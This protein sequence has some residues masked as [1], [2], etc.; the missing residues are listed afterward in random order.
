MY[1][2]EE[3]YLNYG[4]K[5]LEDAISRWRP[6][7]F[8]TFKSA[9]EESFLQYNTL[10]YLG[11]SLAQWSAPNQTPI[12][13]D[14]WNSEHSSFRE[15][16]PYQEEMTEGEA[17]VL[18]TQWD[19]KTR[20]TNLRRN[21]D[22]W[23]LPN[24]A[25]TMLG[26]IPD[27]VNLAGFGGFVGRMG[28]VSK[29]AK[30]LPAIKYTAPV[31]QGA[32]DTALAESLF[33]FTRATYEHTQGGDLDQFSIFGE[34]AL[35]TAFGGMFGTLPM[36]WQIAKKVPPAMHFTY[37]DEAMHRIGRQ[38]KS[39]DTFGNAGVHADEIDVDAETAINRN[40]QRE[41][42]TEA[43]GQLSDLD[44]TGNEIFE[45]ER[46]DWDATPTEE[47]KGI[48]AEAADDI[49]TT[50]TNPAETKRN[51]AEKLVECVRFF[52]SGKKGM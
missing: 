25:G 40:A 1:F 43:E 38:G 20:L 51:I 22:F 42:D 39:N 27:P 9:A 46:Y 32:S 10:G 15:G 5:R 24:L 52:G 29:V 50:L 41:A 14:S 18:A 31:L 21:V 26:A 4:N 12:E 35:A 6:G 30:T 45:H 23:S 17:L 37:L 47:P 13:E 28:T 49:H 34:I 36:A 3:D 7:A 8:E 48:L 11:S 33:Q 19:Q 2:W 16:I 44:E